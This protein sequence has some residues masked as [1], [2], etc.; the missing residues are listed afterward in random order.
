MVL[1]A[2]TI[3]GIGG[4]LMTG[5]YAL[6]NLQSVTTRNSIAVGELAARMEQNDSKTDLNEVR[7]AALEKIAV[8][9]ISL[10]RELEGTVNS[11]R[12]DIAVIKEILTR[13]DEN[14]RTQP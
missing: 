14:K 1:L 12:S 3:I 7:I 11:F 4:A 13:M 6:S 5:G 8:D 10:R 2:G 9:A